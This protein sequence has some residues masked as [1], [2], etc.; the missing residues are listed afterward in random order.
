MAKWLNN[1]ILWALLATSIMIAMLT[2]AS[3]GQ[4]STQKCDEKC[5]RTFYRKF[6][7]ITPPEDI[8]LHPRG[9]PKEGG[10]P[11]EDKNVIEDTSHEA[12]KEGEAKAKQIIRDGLVTKE[13]QDPT[14][15][16]KKRDAT[17]KPVYPKPGEAGEITKAEGDEEAELPAPPADPLTGHFDYTYKGAGGV[18][19]TVTYTY[20]LKF[21]K[22]DQ[23]KPLECGCKPK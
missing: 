18:E 7:G 14:C 17:Q 15:E 4:T 9:S 21:K 10:V 5:E 22:K 8:Q 23:S 11:T 20:R 2:R 19:K 3:L 1:K 6:T 16:C 12:K 13:C